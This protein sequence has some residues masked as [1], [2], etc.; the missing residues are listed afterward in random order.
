VNAAG[1]HELKLSGTDGTTT[2]E[3]SF[4][5]LLNGSVETAEL[6]AGAKEGVVFINGGKSA[7]LT[8]YA[9]FKQYVYAIGVFNDWQSGLP[10]FMKRTPDGNKWWV[11]IDNLQAGKEYAYQYLVDGKLRI[12]DPYTEKVIDPQYDKSIPFSS[13]PSIMPYPTGKTSGIL[14]VMQSS[15]PAYSWTYKSFKRPEKNDLVIYE[16]HLRDFLKDANYNTLRDTLD[17]L[18]KLHVNAIELMPIIG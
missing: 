5:F 6:P 3:R 8:L 15:Q 1:R 17:Y 13:Y 9:P 7:I 11:Q 16:L 14:S 4:T 12:A 18:T 2:I 10:Y